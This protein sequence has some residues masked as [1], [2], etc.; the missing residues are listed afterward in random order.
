[1]RATVGSPSGSSGGGPSVDGP[2]GAAPARRSAARSGAQ[3]RTIGARRVAPP[4]RKRYFAVAT[5]ATPYTVECAP[6]D[7]SRSRVT[8]AEVSGLTPT[9][10]SNVTCGTEQSRFEDAT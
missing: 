7:A 2:E 4:P 3:R 6:G 1:V 5:A 9:I 10:T 8:R